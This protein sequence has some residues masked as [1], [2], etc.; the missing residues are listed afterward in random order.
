MVT[1]KAGCSP[2]ESPRA[3]GAGGFS[4]LA[5]L[6]VSRWREGGKNEVMEGERE[7]G[8]KG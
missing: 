4:H 3:A 8:M 2:P 5:G 7:G 6:D 1:C